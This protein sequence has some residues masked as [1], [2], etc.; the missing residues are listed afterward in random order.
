MPLARRL[1]VILLM[2]SSLVAVVGLGVIAVDLT[3]PATFGW[4]AY[5]P[6][7]HASFVPGAVSTTALVWS[8]VTGAAL[9]GIGFAIGWLVGARGSSRPA[10]RT[11]ERARRDR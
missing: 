8:L 4:F 9:L 1:V 6:L 7:A 11:S 2:A 5:Q 3:T 10:S